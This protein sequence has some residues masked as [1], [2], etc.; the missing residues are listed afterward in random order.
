MKT[1]KSI[2]NNNELR[3]EILKVIGELRVGKTTVDIA[4]TVFNGAGKVMNTIKV[5][6]EYKKVMRSHPEEKIPF[7]EIEV[8]LNK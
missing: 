4:K 5:E 2:K 7:M 6:M 8:D 3:D 1:T